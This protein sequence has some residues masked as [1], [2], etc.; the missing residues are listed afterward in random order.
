MTTAGAHPPTHVLADLAEGVLDDAQAREVRAHVDDC[1]TCQATLDELAQVSV[2]LRAL[3]A[4]LPVP[5]F[6]AARISHALAAERAS[7]A[8]ATAASADSASA[9]DGTVAWFRR[10]L[11]QGLAAAASVAVLGLAG[12]VAV[13]GGGGGNDSDGAGQ[14]AAAE[15][16]A[17]D[18]A[19]AFSQSTPSGVQ[20]DGTPSTAMDTA[21][22]AEDQSV[23]AAPEALEQTRLITAVTEVVQG[24]AD[25]AGPDTCGEEL[26]DELGLPLVGATNVG[27][28]VLVVLDDTATYDGWLITT[29]AST[30]NETMQPQVEVPKSE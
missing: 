14:P 30:T 18:E 25:P 19:S 13:G 3:P 2:A 4:E 22:P 5:E 27:S 15:A 11:P 20:R 21:P 28:G 9:D 6:V 8:A 24:D 12:Y 7:G 16:E 1:P 29:C 23:D 10:R 26:A 17:P